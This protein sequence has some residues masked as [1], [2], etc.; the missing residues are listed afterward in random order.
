MT[1]Q[2]IQLMGDSL[3]LN[4]IE[5]ILGQSIYCKAEHHIIMV[6]GV[7]LDALLHRHYPLYHLEGLVPVMPDWLDVPG[8]REFILSRYKCTS[9]DFVMPILM[10]PDDCDLSC[11]VVVAHVVR[12]GSRV[13]WKKLG[14]DMSSREDMLTGD[15][16]IGTT[17]DWLDEIPELTFRESD[18]TSQFSKIYR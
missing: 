17:V 9:K 4:N 7:S 12:T 11:T 13:V 3:A 18:Y 1:G 5:V 14:I 15:D 2:K 16:P 6:D 8:E 10:C